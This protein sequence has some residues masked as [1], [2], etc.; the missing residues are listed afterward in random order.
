MTTIH[1]SS[2][3]DAHDSFIPKLTNHLKPFLIRLT[4]Q[5]RNW[6][7]HKKAHLDAQ[8]F[9]SP[10]T[11]KLPPPHEEN[12]IYLWK[13]GIHGTNIS[14]NLGNH[15]LSWI[16]RWDSMHPI[17]AYQNSHQDGLIFSSTSQLRKWK[18]IAVKHS[19]GRERRCICTCFK[20]YKV[21]T[22]TISSFLR[23]HKRRVQPDQ[24][25]SLVCAGTKR[26]K[27]DK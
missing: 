19:G 1:C 2:P 23:I 12:R 13:W 20:Y 27:K 10:R 15:Q 8:K 21:E 25:K 3:A 22:I 18:N 11:G 26:W 4:L 5:M 14:I 16:K 9:R 17:E 6:I 7:Y 24:D